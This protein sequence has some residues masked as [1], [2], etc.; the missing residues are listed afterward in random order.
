[1]T[2]RSQAGMPGETLAVKISP[3]SPSGQA[4]AHKLSALLPWVAA[5]VF[6]QGFHN[7]V[8]ASSGA[9][10]DLSVLSFLVGGMCLVLSLQIRR[11]AI[12]PQRALPFAAALLPVILLI[13][14]CH[15]SLAQDSSQVLVVALIVIGSSR[16]PF[17][18]SWI[19]AVQL[20]AV[21]GWVL[22]SSVVL[23]PA[24]AWPLFGALLIVALLS[25][26]HTQR[27]LGRLS[28]RYFGSPDMACDG[29]SDVS[30]GVTTLAGALADSAADHFVNDKLT[31]L[32][33]RNAFL[34]KLRNAVEQARASSQASYTAVLVLDLDSFK[35]INDRLSYEMGDQVLVAAASRLR[36]CLRRRSDDFSARLGADEFGVILRQLQKPDDALPIAKRIQAVLGQAFQI[37]EQQARISASIGVAIGEARDSRAEE[38]LSNADTAMHHVKASRKG[39]IEIFT[40][41]MHSEVMR[42]CRLRSDLWKALEGNELFLHYQPLISL[43]RGHIAGAEALLRWRHPDGEIIPPLEFIPIAEE[44]GLIEPIGEWVIETACSQ[45]AAWQRAGLPPVPV[46]VNLSV[47][48]L[49]QPGFCAMVRRVLEDTGLRADYLEL[50]LT[51]TMLMDNL[52]M[53]LTVIGQLTEMGVKISIDDFGT[54]YSSLG[55]LKRLPCDK[56]KIDRSFVADLT[57]DA[58][59]AAIVGGLINLAHN[60]D[61]QVTAEG[62]EF[63]EQMS[64]LRAAGCDQMQGHF[65]SPPLEPRPFAELLGSEF[66]LYPAP[67]LVRSER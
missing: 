40:P 33:T 3:E 26:P 46:A 2:K 50:E 64:F 15:L 47:H 63:E 45:N 23:P 22:V 6:L 27:E 61:L 25:S 54:G 7:L 60:L 4:R 17:A 20:A 29:K 62:V 12:P 58:K 14:L 42:S 39:T 30:S 65:V 38:L 21:G 16:L 13:S 9:V 56:L 28:P 24:L 31:G 51:E 18:L 41:R 55:Y 10:R 59:S 1:M 48:Q 19:T 5:L 44:T 34:L 35:S 49:R 11:E 66:N 32:P 36:G 37:G 67:V 57:H 8:S 43:R 52:E 53:A